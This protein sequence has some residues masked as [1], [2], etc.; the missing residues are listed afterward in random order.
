MTAGTKLG[1]SRARPIPSIREGR[2]GGAACVCAAVA[3]LQPAGVERGVLRIDDGE[4]R[5]V[6]VVPEVA[7]DGGAGAAGAG[8]HHDPAGDRVLLEGEL[9][10]DRLGDVVVAAPVRGPLGVGELVHVVAVGAPGEVPGGLVDLRGVVHEQAGAAELLDQ[11]D[12]LPA[13]GPGHHRDER[14]PQ[15]LGKIGFRNGRAAA[16]GLHDG[17]AFRDPAVDQPEEEQRAG[18][19]VLQAAGAVG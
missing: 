8:A 18:Q 15:Q 4:F 17:G 12:L 10:E 7:A 19:P 13:G 1:S 6:A 5:V 3:A 14:Q 16:G 9:A 11:G 2:P